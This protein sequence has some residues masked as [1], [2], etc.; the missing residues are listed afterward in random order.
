MIEDTEAAAVFAITVT[1]RC[2]ALKDCVMPVSNRFTV[3]PRGSRAPI[4]T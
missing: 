4:S 1:V 2:G 3:A